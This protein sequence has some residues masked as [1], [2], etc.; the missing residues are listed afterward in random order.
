MMEMDLASHIIK[1]LIGLVSL[2]NPIAAIPIFLSLCAGKPANSCKK[3]PYITTISI[4]V[5]LII[6]I[7]FGDAV[8]KMFGISISAFQAAGGLII[9]LM[10]I[11][12]L[13][14]KQ[15]PV[16]H[17]ASENR[18]MNERDH[19]ELTSIAIVPLAI[20]LM[21]GPGT[22]SFGIIQANEVVDFW[23][24]RLVLTGIALIAALVALVTLVM[25]QPIGK[26]LG[27]TGLN[28]ITRVM[29]MI[30]AAIGMQMITVGLLKL[31]PGLGT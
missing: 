1:T 31:L 11:D 20:P 12:M 16:K 4:S 23:S 27:A 13:H 24:G 15:T 14:A 2:M 3:L 25:A 5:I 8:L 18:E 6:S 7:W 21:A 28:I 26:K 9:L 29:G 22:I 19:S 30:L 17:T 10:A